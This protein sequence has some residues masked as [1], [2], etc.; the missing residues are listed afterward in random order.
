MINRNEFHLPFMGFTANCMYMYSLNKLEHKN[1]R[2]QVPFGA[3]IQSFQDAIRRIFPASTY[4]PLVIITV[5]GYAIFSILYKAIPKIKD[6]PSFLDFCLED[7]PSAIMWLAIGLIGASMVQ[8]INLVDFFLGM[9][10]L[11]TRQE[12]N[13][14]QDEYIPLARRV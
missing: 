9:I 5:S 14:I 11:V 6:F 13:P 4:E 1:L 7:L 8:M 12:P 10:K 3:K 2:L